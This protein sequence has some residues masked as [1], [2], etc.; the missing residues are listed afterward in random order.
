MHFDVLARKGIVHRHADGGMNRPKNR[1]RDFSA[2]Q[3]LQALPDRRTF[4]DGDDSL[5]IAGDRHSMDFPSDDVF[6]M[7]GG[8]AT[9][10][11]SVG[12]RFCDWCHIVVFHICV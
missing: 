4:P 10:K 6:F 7:R 11:H 8:G 2:D 1:Q 5:F 12:V 3:K 9:S